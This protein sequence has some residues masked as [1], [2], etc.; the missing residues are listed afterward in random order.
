MKRTIIFYLFVCLGL[1]A[2]AQTKTEADSLY[3]KGKY[4]QAAKVYEQVLTQGEHAYLYYNLGNAYYRMG[5]MG[6]AILAYERAA[7]RDPGNSDIRFNLALARTK[8]IDKT[9]DTDQFFIAYWFRSLLNTCGTDVW[10]ICAVV[11]FVLLLLFIVLRMLISVPWVRL[12]LPWGIGACLLACILFNTFAYLQRKQV[13][14]R[15]YAII[16]QTLEVKS[17][18]AASGNTL[19]TLHPGTKVKISDDTMKDWKEVTLSDG[20]KGWLKTSTIEMI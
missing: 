4:E 3:A 17:T 14:D 2:W 10:A 13:L 1:M 9:E 16:M 19:F 6:K 7:V 18:P 11:A 20:K 5:D 12:C 8:T 15:S